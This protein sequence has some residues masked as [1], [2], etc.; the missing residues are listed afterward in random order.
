M[1]SEGKLAGMEIPFLVFGPS[2]M[3]GRGIG[4][5]GERQAEAWKSH[6]GADPG[7]DVDVLD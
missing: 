5:Q 7:S 1:R 2:A 4:S 6:V 3:M